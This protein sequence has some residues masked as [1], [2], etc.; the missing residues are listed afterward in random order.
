M[1]RT[2]RRM[3]EAPEV[4][5]E[6]SE[7]DLFRFNRIKAFADSIAKSNKRNGIKKGFQNA[8]IM[9]GSENLFLFM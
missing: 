9:E 7:F 8:I 6:S 2:A 3:A 1:D 5:A 4:E